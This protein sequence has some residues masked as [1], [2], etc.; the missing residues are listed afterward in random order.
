MAKDLAFLHRQPIV[1]GGCGDENRGNRTR[2]QGKLLQD[3][4]RNGQSSFET[5]PRV[6]LFELTQWYFYK[7]DFPWSPISATIPS[8]QTKIS[9]RPEA[10]SIHR[11]IIPVKT[12]DIA[13]V[14]VQLIDA[15]S[16]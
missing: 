16:V 6:R 2:N 13:S 4:V 15:Y 11:K 5:L 9:A 10:P 14:Q 8:E 7:P 3:L 12:I 1:H